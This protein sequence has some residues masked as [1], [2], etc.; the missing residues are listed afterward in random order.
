MVVV[1]GRTPGGKVSGREGV[2]LSVTAWFIWALSNMWRRSLNGDAIAPVKC[3]V[4]VQF[5]IAMVT[6]GC[7][8]RQIRDRAQEDLVLMGTAGDV[9]APPPKTRCRMQSYVE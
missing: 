4:C 6:N 3:C 7:Q 1:A 9:G 5:R 8:A 2:C